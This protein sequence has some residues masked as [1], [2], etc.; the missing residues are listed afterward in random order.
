M[1]AALE[2]EEHF[3]VPLVLYY[4]QCL[5]YKEIAEVMGIS[6][7]TVMSRLSRGKEMLRRRLLDRK[8]T[9]KTTPTNVV[10]AEESFRAT[11]I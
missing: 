8:Q 1:E 5:T 3:R 4:L 6:I 11:L 10:A 2:L 7:G 9:Q